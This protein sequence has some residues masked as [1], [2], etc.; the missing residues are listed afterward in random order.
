MKE[1]YCVMKIMASWMTLDQLGVKI[2]ENISQTAVERK[3]RNSSH[4][5]SNLGLI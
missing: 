5:G 2:Q 1:P 3:R 4:T